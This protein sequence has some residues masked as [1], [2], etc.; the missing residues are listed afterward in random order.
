MFSSSEN[1]A[2]IPPADAARRTGRERVALEQDDVVDAELA[3]VPGDARAHRAAADDDDLACFH[4]LT[5]ELKVVRRPRREGVA[6]YPPMRRPD[7]PSA[8]Q[9]FPNPLPLA[10]PGFVSPEKR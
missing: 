1:C 9:T 8:N 10:S 7:G 2:R 6:A 3:Q 4:S 5:R